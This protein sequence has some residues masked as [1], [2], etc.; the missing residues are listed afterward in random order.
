MRVLILD[1]FSN[2]D[3]AETTRLIHGILEKSGDFKVETS[4]CPPTGTKEWNAWKPDFNN[5]DVIIQNCNDIQKNGAW[6]EAVKH[7]L[8]QFVSSGGGLFVWHSANNAFADWPAYNRMIGLGWRPKN[9][10][11]A[12]RINDDGSSVRIP[13]GE[14]ANTSHGNRVDTLVHRL[15]EHPIHASLP[16]SWMTPDLEVYSHPRGPAENLSVLSYGFDPVTKQNWPLEWTVDYG[17]GRIYTATYGHVWKDEKNPAR[18]R[19]AAVQT[20]TVRAVFWLA[21]KP[22]PAKVP[23]DFPTAKHVSIRSDD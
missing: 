20:I 7:S 6:P 18:M 4:T 19:C 23:A 17:T 1:G 16:R 3:W 8:D 15:G 11:T 10:G 9:V 14:G 12:I 22:I 5:A 13:P 2:H 21:K